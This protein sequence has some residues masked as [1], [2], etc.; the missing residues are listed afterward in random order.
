[1]KSLQNRSAATNDL[2]QKEPS[3]AQGVEEEKGPFFGGESVSKNDAASSVESKPKNEM[4]SF[5]V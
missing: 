3:N 4:E 2:V 5:S 1:M